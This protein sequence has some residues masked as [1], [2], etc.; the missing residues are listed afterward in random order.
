MNG[1]GDF[2]A[3]ARASKSRCEFFGPAI[4]MSVDIAR[5]ANRHA[6]NRCNDEEQ[7]VLFDDGSL[8]A[9]DDCAQAERFH[10]GVGN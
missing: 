2:G 10:D 4:H 5:F 9:D 6:D 8:N 7:D 3:F 1:V